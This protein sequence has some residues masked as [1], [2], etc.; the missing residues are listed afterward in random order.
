MHVEAY[1]WV[2][3]HST[4]E[5]V[6]VIDLGGR[7]VNGSCRPLF[8]NA[9]SYTVLDI[10]D[11]PNVDIVADAAT[12]SPNGYRFDVALATEVFEHSP[13]WPEIVMTAYKAL[14]VGGVFIATMA[15]PGRPV[16]SAVDGGGWLHP[17]EHYANVHPDDLRRVLEGAGFVG[18]VVD[19]QPEPADVRAVAMKG[20]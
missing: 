20:A 3:R 12:W 19:Q 14:R 2:A 11:G 5:P 18:I 9:T 17:G 13:V 15:G 8:P 7:D 16:H 10:A 4:D 1:E 6:S